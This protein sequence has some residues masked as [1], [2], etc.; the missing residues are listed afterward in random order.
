M[1]AR[2]ECDEWYPV[3]SL[4]LEHMTSGTFMEL[5]DEEWAD[6]RRVMDKFNAWQQRLE[7]AASE[8]Y[9][10][11]SPSICKFC[12]TTEGNVHW[13]AQRFDG[14]FC[15]EHDPVMHPELKGDGD[16]S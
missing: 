6:Y 2:I 13:V 5:T 12:G 10:P 16:D 3:Y 11:P 8:P 14:H 7:L 1:K 15:D 4:E 9:V